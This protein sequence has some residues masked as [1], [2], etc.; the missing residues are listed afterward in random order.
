MKYYLIT[1][2]MI[3]S[4]CSCA[5]NKRAVIKHCIK[6]EGKN[7]K[8]RDLIDIDGYFAYSNSA[9]CGL[10]FYD[11]GSFVINGHAKEGA[12][13]ELVQ[14]NMTE[15][16]Y[17]W[18][19]NKGR[20][21][22]GNEHGTYR[23]EGDTIIAQTIFPS[24]A[25]LRGWESIE[26]RYKVIDRTTI[27]LFYK[28]YSPDKANSGEKVSHRYEYIPCNFIPTSDNPVKEYKWIWRNESDWKDLMQKI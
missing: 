28:S 8:I 24:Y 14:K 23:I 11:D 21:R 7:T 12:T 6:L 2:L 1:L 27:E 20:L 18:I 4:F 19:D 13:I 17:S 25:L 3:F 5:T 16:T 9:V 26:Y 22:W 15:W 10:T